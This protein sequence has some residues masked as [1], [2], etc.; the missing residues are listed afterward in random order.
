MEKNETGFGRGLRV[1]LTGL[2]GPWRVLDEI[3]RE[4]IWRTVSDCRCWP[5]ADL[6]VCAFSDSDTG[7]SVDFLNADGG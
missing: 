6:E 1:E 3:V 2:S 7:G 5:K 4:K